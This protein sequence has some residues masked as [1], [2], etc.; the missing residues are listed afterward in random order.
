[1]QPEADI[2]ET[3]YNDYCRQ[4]AEMDLNR[5][6]EIL[7]IEVDG[8][9][10]LVPFFNETFK[11][12]GDGILDAAGERAHYGICVLVAKYLLRCPDQLYL[13]RGWISF[14]DFKQSGHFT[15]DNFIKSDT[16]KVILKRFS[17]DLPGLIKAGQAL[18]G[19]HYDGDFSYDITFRFDVLPRL[20]LL[21]LFNDRDE[22]FP[23]QVSVLF[24]GHAES[25]LDP[26]SLGIASAVLAKRLAGGSV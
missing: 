3:H 18:G 5:A 9:T 8:Q 16:E 7:G 14:K 21:L 6:K 19:S 20:S 2:F 17:G 4:I 10:A 23:A 24:S 25:Y 22:E 13:T 15:N 1:M 26:E 12:S 11:V